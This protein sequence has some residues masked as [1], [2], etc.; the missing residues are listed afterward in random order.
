MPPKKTTAFNFEQALSELGQLVEKMEQ[1]N[2]SLE[3][4]LADFERGIAL[5]QQC[6]SALQSAEQKVKLLVEK[7]GHAILMDYHPTTDPNE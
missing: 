6:Q 2:L 3:E 1:G 4:S 7:N 5:T